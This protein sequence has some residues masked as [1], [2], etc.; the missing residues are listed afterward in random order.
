MGVQLYGLENVFFYD[1]PSKNSY[2]T[3][4]GGIQEGEP[5][6]FT[7]NWLAPRFP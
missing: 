6:Y 3:W 5:Q 4:S 7:K 1:R 2:E